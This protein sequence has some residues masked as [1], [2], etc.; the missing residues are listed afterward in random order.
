MEIRVTQCADSEEAIVEI[1]KPGGDGTPDEVV[2]TTKLL[3]GQSVAVSVDGA[4]EPSDLEVGEVTT[5]EPTEPEGD[6]AE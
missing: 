2:S 3:N 5:P 1:V 6:E 4:T